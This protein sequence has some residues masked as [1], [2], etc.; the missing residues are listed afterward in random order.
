MLYLT[1][2]IPLIYFNS[3]YLP[4]HTTIPFILCCSGLSLLFFLLHNIKH[5]PSYPRLTSVS[6]HISRTSYMHGKASVHAHVPMVATPL[7][8]RPLIH[9]SPSQLSFFKKNQ[10][11]LF[12]LTTII[13]CSSLSCSPFRYHVH[14]HV[15]Y[16]FYL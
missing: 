1:Q 12:Y 8:L 3:Q 15:H 11:L 10:A 5:C 4:S 6:L 14:C 16:H 7:G 9:L 2:Y 13:L